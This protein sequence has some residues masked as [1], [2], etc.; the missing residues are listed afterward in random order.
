MSNTILTMEHIEKSFPGVH[1][2]SDCHFDL[3]SGEVH[4]IV[5][6]NGAGKSTLMKVLTGVYKKDSGTI[7]Y[8]GKE[9]EPQNQ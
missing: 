1:A 3:K 2:L 5:G 8:M 4:S 7:T 6:E 9:L